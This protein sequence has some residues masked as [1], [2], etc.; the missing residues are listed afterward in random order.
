MKT[1][2]DFSKAKKNPYYKKLKQQITL[3]VNREAITYFKTQAADIG[4]PYQTLID[5]YLWD[6]AKSRKKPSLQWLK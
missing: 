5:L 4:I 3:R 6:L 2:Y 1:E